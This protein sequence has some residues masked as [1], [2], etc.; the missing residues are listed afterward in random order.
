[1]CSRTVVEIRL[2]AGKLICMS[3]LPLLEPQRMLVWKLVE[4][5]EAFWVFPGIGHLLFQKKL[6]ETDF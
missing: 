4:Q 6:L 2:F 3:L 5:V 1:M